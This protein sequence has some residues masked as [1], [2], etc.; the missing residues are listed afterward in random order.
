MSKREISDK[1]KSSA[2]LRE[3]REILA[4]KPEADKIFHGEVDRRWRAIPLD[5]RQ[6]VCKLAGCEEVAAFD[7][8]KIETK[9][10]AKIRM[11]VTRLRRL[12]KQG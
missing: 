11:M 2:T 7:Y 9:D 5:Q 12:V 1:E 10:R 6:W 3:L 8:S 4:K